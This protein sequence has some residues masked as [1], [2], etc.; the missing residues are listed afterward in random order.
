MGN[1]HTSSVHFVYIGTDTLK[2]MEPASIPAMDPHNHSGYKNLGGVDSVITHGVPPRQD[3]TVLSL[4]QL[5]QDLDPQSVHSHYSS[6]SDR[7]RNSSTSFNRTIKAWRDAVAAACGSTTSSQKSHRLNAPSFSGSMRANQL[8]YLD[9]LLG[10][11]DSVSN[12][13]SDDDS[14]ALSGRHTFTVPASRAQSYPHSRTH[15]RTSRPPPIH[16]TTTTSSPDSTA[17]HMRVTLED[18]TGR[19]LSVQSARRVIFQFP[20][21]LDGMMTVAMED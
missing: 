13:G 17:Q 16:T 20:S 21:F 6:R 10:P 2:T 15:L 11:D 3:P 1:H 8:D 18:G 4:Q 14:D 9:N 12:Q 19:N 5:A 7:F